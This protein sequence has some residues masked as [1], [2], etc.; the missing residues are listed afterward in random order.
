[1]E[2]KDY[3]KILGVSREAGQDDIK[4]AY[5]KL[6]HKYHPDVSKEP[7]AERKFKEMKEAYEVLGDP[8]KR[9]AYDQLGSGY[10]QGQSFEPPPE[11]EFGFGRGGFSDIGA[12]EFS[13][14][15]ESLFRGGS[16]GGRDRSG[17]TGGKGYPGEDQHAR[18]EIDLEDAFHGA[19]RRIQVQPADAVG[20]NTGGPKTLDVR[21]P[22][23]VRDGQQIRLAG[24]GRQGLARGRPGDLYLEVRIRPHPHYRLEGRDLYLDLP[25]T[26]WEAA[27]GASV[28]VPTLAG[29][30]TM[31][32]PPGA[33]SGQ[34]LRLK[35]RGLPGNRAG[36][37]YVVLQVRAPQPE[38]AEQRQLYQ[39][40]ARKMPFNPR[41]HLGV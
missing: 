22:A 11:W 13:D 32:I 33:Q 39:E 37:Q 14:F 2:Y 15:F 34:K 9:K 10:R 1:M 31:K 16:F 25:V 24:Q 28:R 30:V 17:A 3:Y 5:R 41:K 20:R 6:A 8:E 23:G 4:R 40:M 35:G 36:D 27:L 38:T 12:E 26:P 18:I 29:P 19:R 7:D 21:I